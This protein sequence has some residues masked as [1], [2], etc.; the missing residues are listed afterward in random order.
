MSDTDLSESTIRLTQIRDYHQRTKHRFEGYA[1]GPET[2]DW[3]AQPA[4]FRHFSGAPCRDLPRLSAVQPDSPLSEALQRPFAQLGQQTPL[5]ATLETLGVWL[6]LA[7][8]L[9][10]WKSYGPDRWVVRANPSSGNLHPTE[11][12]VWV[13][14]F[15]ELEDGIYHYEPEH[16]R[17]ACRAR[18]DTTASTCA[19]PQLAVILTSVM[20]REVWKYGERAFRYCQLDTGHAMAALRYAAAVLGWSLT[21][22]SHIGTQTL[23]HGV[24]VDRLD[25]FPARRSPE[26][27]REEAETLLAVGLEGCPPA[28]VSASAL[29]TLAETAQWYGVASTIDSHPMYRWP[30][31]TEVAEA[32]RRGE[33]LPIAR[34]SQAA[35]PVPYPDTEPLMGQ[36]SVQQLLI[37]RRS[38]QRFDSSQVMPAASFK[39]LLARLHPTDSVPWDTLNQ[40]PR[41][42]LVLFVSQVEGLMPGLYLLPRHPELLADLQ[43]R[44]ARQF[45]FDPVP[46]FEGLWCLAT[47]ELLELKRLSRSL[48]CHQDI[49]GSACLALGMLAR[50]E[51]A[52]VEAGPAAYRDLY[53]EAGLIG[54]LLYL[55]AEA[56]QLRGTGIGCFFDDPVH[57]LLGLEGLDWQSL[58]HFTLGRPIVDPRI[59]STPAYT[60]DSL[61]SPL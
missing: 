9:T 61:S 29:Q 40:G 3:D 19:D 45:V 8:G 14:G 53:R 43:P 59:E 10:A 52:L 46:G 39:A 26:T 51:S 21:E 25:E 56:Q 41:I 2:L 16:H 42:A 60:E 37:Q 6:Q 55:E 58:Y 49:A 38:A 31:I 22:Q 32:S 34:A 35:L 7:L 15:P 17:L 12:Y 28:S 44:L 11:A 24:G 5:P 36:Q 33:T 30:I 50:F 54:Q 48:H 1:R 13:R 23:A 47:M 27:E 4:P 20:W 18:H 57:T